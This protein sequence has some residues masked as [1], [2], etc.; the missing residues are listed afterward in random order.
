VCVC[1]SCCASSIEANSQT[2]TCHRARFTVQRYGRDSSKGLIQR[3][4][5]NNESVKIKMPQN[6]PS[7]SWCAGIQPPPPPGERPILHLELVE[8]KILCGRRRVDG[9][10]GSLVLLLECIMARRG[11]SSGVIARLPLLA[12]MF[13]LTK[14]P[15]PPNSGF[16]ATREV[17]LSAFVTHLQVP[18]DIIQRITRSAR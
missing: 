4:K 9:V 13:I 11:V 8:T 10:S 3:N 16:T 5:Y 12:L 2:G 18:L 6:V 15:H 1:T 7:G 17:I 14:F